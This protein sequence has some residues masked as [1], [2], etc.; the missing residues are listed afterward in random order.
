[1]RSPRPS[2]RIT[3]DLFHVQGLYAAYGWV[4]LHST[5]DRDEA[6]ARLRKYRARNVAMTYQI[7]TQ[8]VR[9]KT[10]PT[11]GVC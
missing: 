8:R 1:M 3:Y 7:D 2:R 6:E 4:T 11:V 9:S 5:F 10:L